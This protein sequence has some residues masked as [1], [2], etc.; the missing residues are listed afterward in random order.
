MTDITYIFF[1]KYAFEDGYYQI[2]YKPES[3]D[4][5]DFELLHKV[6]L[7]TVEKAE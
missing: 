6:F 4:T 5:A 1:Y 7:N 3:G 2:H